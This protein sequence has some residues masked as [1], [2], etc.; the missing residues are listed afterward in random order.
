MSSD[1]LFC[2]FNVMQFTIT[3]SIYTFIS[4]V[5][6]SIHYNIRTYYAA[7]TYRAFYFVRLSILSYRVIGVKQY[8]CKQQLCLSGL[9]SGFVVT[10][11]N[12]WDDDNKCMQ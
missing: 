4:L 6:K 7:F 3:D 11:M 8:S 2:Y 9:S 12:V 1:A 10:I 5:A